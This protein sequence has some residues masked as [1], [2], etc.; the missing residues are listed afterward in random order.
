MPCVADAPKRVDFH[1]VP[2]PTHAEMSSSAYELISDFY[3]S[4]DDVI[5]DVAERIAAA[6]GSHSESD[7]T[8]V[9][10]ERDDVLEA[11]K[12]FAD[13]IRPLV[14]DGKL[15]PRLDDLVKKHANDIAFDY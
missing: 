15:P 4:V 11:G 2:T 8:I 14:K 5:R 7:A 10:V 1:S 6:R 13:A 3:N 9:F 12:V